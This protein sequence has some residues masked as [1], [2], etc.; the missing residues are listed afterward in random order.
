MKNNFIKSGEKEISVFTMLPI[1]FKKAPLLSTILL[2]LTVL[3]G[4][5]LS[6]Q[7]FITTNLINHIMDAVE[8][9]HLY[10]S[11][12]E[13]ILF[14]LILGY[15]WL[16][17][18][19]KRILLIKV[20][21]NISEY[22]DMLTIEKVYNLK[23]YHIESKESWNVISRVKPKLSSNVIK[24]FEDILGFVALIIRV[25]GI[26]GLIF[27]QVWWSAIL[28]IILLLPLSFLVN[29]SAHE[30]YEAEKK[31]TENN[32]RA[33]YFKN[34]FSSKEL[35]DERELFGFGTYLNQKFK[36]S[37]ELAQNIRFQTK[38]IWFV[39]MKTGSL[40]ASLCLTIIIFSFLNPVI[41]GTITIGFFISITQAVFSLIQRLSWDLTGYVDNFATMNEFCKDV[42]KFFQLEEEK[43]LVKDLNRK[44][45]KLSSV[46]FENV[47]FQYPGNEHYVLKNVS[48][49]LNQKKCYAF[50]G[51]NGSGK[52]TII[53]LL[54]GLYDNYTGTIRVNGQ[55]IREL[56]S[57]ELRSLIYPLF[58]DFARYQISIK[59]NIL[60]GDVE[61]MEDNEEKLN[62]VI[63][64]VGMHQFID[65]LPNGVNTELG[66]IGIGSVELSGGQWQRISIMRALIHLAPLKILDE[67]T[68][69]LDPISESNL[70]Q[71]FNHMMENCMTILIS[72]RLGATKLADEI[73]VIDQGSMKEHGT[74][75]ELL[76]MNG[77]YANMFHSQKAWYAE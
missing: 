68:A 20:N 55:N 18:D 31:I 34:I 42:N 26:I 47:S 58:Q 14:C 5:A 63:H 35:V 43:E 2:F 3:D 45:C 69:A 17:Q 53:K 29:K 74:H 71:E 70:Y 28:I 64:S 54:S 21:I 33:E 36:D 73:F 67:P 76:K 60:L 52:T 13:V 19:I 51:A 15:Q 40:T 65:S 48:F 10:A 56:S 72:H 27:T 39:K 4:L 16:S 61:R 49:L 37:Y 22:L 30:N 7:V 38:R 9:K 50:V 59:D 41:K 12:K 46:A 23:Y 6:L 1:P 62:K 11:T 66:K 57:E 32:R 44:P 24:F 25:V 77:T 8:N 75:E